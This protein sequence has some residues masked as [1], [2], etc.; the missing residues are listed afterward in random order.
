LPCRQILKRLMPPVGQVG[1]T[2]VHA[3]KFTWGRTAA[4]VADV[5]REL[6]S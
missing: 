3:A 5:I 2:I 4:G 6:L 1:G